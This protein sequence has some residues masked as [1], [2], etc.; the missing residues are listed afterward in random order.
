MIITIQRRLDAKESPMAMKILHSFFNKISW[1]SV[2]QFNRTSGIII[3]YS[4]I[5]WPKVDWCPTKNG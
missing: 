5:N 3:L 1:E 4:S 2:L